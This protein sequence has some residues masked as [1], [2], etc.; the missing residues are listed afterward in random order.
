[1]DEAK[2]TV[3]RF[4]P[5]T[6]KEARYQTYT[7]PAGGWKDLKV[8]DT[9]RY[10]RQHLDGSLAFRESCRQYQICSACMMMVNKKLSLACEV[11]ATPEM[12][13]EPAA[14]YTLLKD[15]IVS[16]HRSGKEEGI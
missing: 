4:D 3:Y 5:T 14:N 1:M 15:L 13:I 7:V 11:M 8:L 2:V 10:I 12:L 9:L 6:D 16:F